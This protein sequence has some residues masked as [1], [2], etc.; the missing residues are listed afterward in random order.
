[1]TVTENKYLIYDRPVVKNLK[2]YT[3]YFIVVCF[4]LFYKLLFLKKKDFAPKKYHIS[5]C[6]CFKNEAR[7]FKEWIEYHQMIGVEHFYLYNNNS[8]D[9]Y[10]EVLQEYIDKG[11]VTLE[12]YPEVPVQPGAYQHWYKTYRHET[13]WVTFLD[14][15]EFYVPLKH[16][17]LT[18]WLK[19]HDRYPLLLVYWK[20]FGTSGIMKHDESKLCA[21]QYTVSWPKLD[22]I[23]KQFY[24]TNYDLVSIERG[25]MHYMKV[26]YHGFKIPPMNGYGHF[27]QAGIHRSNAKY[28]DMQ[29]NHY[30]SKAFDIYEL[31]HK[32]GSSAFGKSWKTFDQFCWHENHNTSSDFAIYRFLVQLKLRMQE[33]GNNIGEEQKNS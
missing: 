9:N 5:I 8:D 13:D 33:N 24:N 20:M 11:V 27:V 17:T 10:Q 16:D 22:A 18:G 21:E 30:W 31:K 29:L 32:R 15:D 6:G 2:Y 1:M 3:Y 14:M 26:R 28:P 23:G 25:S 7:F 4:E 12:Q 19:T